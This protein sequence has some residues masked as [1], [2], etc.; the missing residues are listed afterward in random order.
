[1]KILHG[2]ELINRVFMFEPDACVNVFKNEV[3][4]METTIY[5]RC[6]KCGK[7]L[8]NKEARSRGYG[9]KCWQIH[10]AELIEN[11]SLLKDDSK[12]SR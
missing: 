8:K 6:L 1:M 4:C 2:E 11:D 3:K 5:F 9:F 12:K 10:T 7:P